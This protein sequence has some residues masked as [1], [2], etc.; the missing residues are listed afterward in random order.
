MTPVEVRLDGIDAP[1]KNQSFGTKSRDA[2]ASLVSGKTVTVQSKATDRYGRTPGRRGGAGFVRCAPSTVRVGQD[3]YHSF[4]RC[5]RAAFQ[6]RQCGVGILV[7]FKPRQ[8][9]A[10]NP[11]AFVD[12]CKAQS[13]SLSF[14]SKCATKLTHWSAFVRQKLRLTCGTHPDNR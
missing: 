5:F 10:V 11:C 6:C 13:E 4:P 7:V 8:G 12:I 14:G 2:L 3:H 1:E 9:R